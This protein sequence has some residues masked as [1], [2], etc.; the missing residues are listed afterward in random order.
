MKQFLFLVFIGWV[1]AAALSGCRTQKPAPERNVSRA[2]GTPLPAHPAV[3]AP[4]GSLD[5]ATVTPH[6]SL[7]D[8]VL[9]RPAPSP[10]PLPLGGGGVKVG[11]KSTVNIYHG[12]ATVTNNTAG[13]NA[14]AG[15]GATAGGKADGPVAGTGATATDNTKAGQRG[16]AAATAPGATATATTIKPPTPWLKYGLWLA[17]GLGAYWLLFG[18]GGAVLLALFRRNKSTSNQV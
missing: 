1:I 3:E 15:A 13:K 16:G 12:P 9:G 17:G 5:S 8:K 7:L 4:H 10:R 6:R 18:G 14:A 11:K 2:E